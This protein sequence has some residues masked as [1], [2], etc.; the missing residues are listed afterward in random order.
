ME[1]L[2]IETSLATCQC[3]AQYRHSLNFKQGFAVALLYACPENK[4]EFVSAKTVYLFCKR[5]FE[6]SGK[7]SHS[8]RYNG[9]W[10]TDT[11]L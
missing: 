8:C 4:G 5:Q 7:A 11:K 3:S 2:G 10:D 6:L 1:K 9:M